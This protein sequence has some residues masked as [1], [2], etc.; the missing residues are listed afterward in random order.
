MIGVFEK[1]DKLGKSLILILKGFPCSWG[2]CIFCPFILDQS[3]NVRDVMLTNRELIK[4]AIRIVD[5]KG[6]RRVAVF[7]GGSFH[8]LPFDTIEKL[9][10]LARDRIFEIEER[11]EFVTFNSIKFILGMYDLEKLVIRIGFEVIDEK[12]RNNYLRKGIPDEELKRIVKLRKNLRASGLPVELW[13]YVLFG[14]EGISEELV[15]RSV[16]KFKDMLDGVI[17][18]KYKKY[19]PGHPKEVPVSDNLRKYLQEIADLVDWGD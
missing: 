9:S 8:E 18:V 4:R 7:N 15:L 16:K 10:K 19:L 14:I 3:T 6:Y 12:I 17:A 1:E 13:T 5:V 11:P 2:K